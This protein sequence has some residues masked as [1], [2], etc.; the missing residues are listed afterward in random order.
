M[1]ASTEFPADRWAKR[2]Y[3]ETDRAGHAEPKEEPARARRD[4]RRMPAH[5]KKRP[6]FFSR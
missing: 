3:V 4:R 5:G 6:G 1:S 2:L